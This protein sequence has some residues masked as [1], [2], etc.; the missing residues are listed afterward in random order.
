M[1]FSRNCSPM[2]V[3]CISF[4]NG[5][6]TYCNADHRRC[7]IRTSEVETPLQS[8]ACHP[9]A[10]DS[11]MP[12]QPLAN[13]SAHGRGSFFTRM[14]FRLCNGSKL[15]CSS[16]IYRFPSGHVGACERRKNSPLRPHTWKPQSR[17]LTAARF[18]FKYQALT[19]AD[20]VTLC[21][22]LAVF[23]GHT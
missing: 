15:A 22:S 9:K 19:F 18:Y 14:L 13:C 2:A 11:F 5:R 12:L 20:D 17:E 21:C 3:N 10:L 16:S 23:V 8:I 1:S 7:T 6:Q 4:T